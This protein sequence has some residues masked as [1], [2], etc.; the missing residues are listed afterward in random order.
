MSDAA[1]IEDLCVK[2][3]S[4]LTTPKDGPQSPLRRNSS[5]VIGTYSYLF[6]C[7]TVNSTNQYGA[8]LFNLCMIRN[9]Q[10]ISQY[11]DYLT[12]TQAAILHTLSSHKCPT[13]S[14]HHYLRTV[15]TLRRAL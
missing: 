9:P 8:R 7:I 11:T 10:R 12:I 6:N 5:G 3:N 2:A 13:G 14:S 4:I 15:F 1:L